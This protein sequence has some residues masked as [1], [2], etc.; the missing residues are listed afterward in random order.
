MATDLKNNMEI[1]IG[2]RWKY[3]PNTAPDPASYFAVVEIIE[4]VPKY[5]FQVEV[6]QVQG[7]LSWK[8]G[9]KFCPAS[10]RLDGVANFWECLEGQD[11]G[12]A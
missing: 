6:L 5:A 10:L 7:L 3:T 11:K 12:F 9:Q 8:I 1:K 4:S 2:Q